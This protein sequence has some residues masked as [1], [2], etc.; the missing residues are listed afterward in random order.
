[1]ET[2]LFR[3]VL[4]VVPAMAAG[5]RLF[6]LL[7]LVEADFRV[8]VVFTV[9]GT[10]PEVDR[11]V[12]EQGGLVVPWSQAIRHE[13]ELVLAADDRHVAQLSGP[14]LILSEA[15]GRALCL[16]R[17]RASL[18]F[19]A[20]YR[21]ALGA[22]GL[23]VTMCSTWSRGS[24][25][26]TMPELCGELLAELPPDRGCVALVLHPRVWAA[27]GPRQVRAWLSPYLD[28]GLVLVQEAWRATLI[29][30]DWVLGDHGSATAYA[31]AVGAPVTMATGADQLRCGPGDVL[32]QFAP[33][34]QH[35]RALLS[36][37]RIAAQR[38]AQLRR[39]IA[40]EIG[41]T[42]GTAAALRA[43]MYELL[44]MPELDRGQVCGALRVP[45]PLVRRGRAPRAGTLACAHGPVG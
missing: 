12:A 43:T 9:P 11:Y 28:A 20:T 34:L 7:P 29:A 19:R 36:Q 1:M 10:A 38:A 24:V 41:A 3:R 40:P 42:P 4:V 2:N 37:R 31:A 23:L 39:V 22:D 32:R 6:D 17:M 44:D 45:G 8:R 13:W 14:V 27:Y 25:F 16:D 33:R 21:E 15:D 26:E 5:A 18:P 35:D 30:A